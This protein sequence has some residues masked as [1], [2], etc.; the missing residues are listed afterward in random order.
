MAY[1]LA[2]KLLSATDG[3]LQIILRYYPQAAD[4]VQ[5]ANTK[6]SIREEKTPSAAL[7]N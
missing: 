7:K 6:F 1:E 2:E 4:A 5:R 3:G